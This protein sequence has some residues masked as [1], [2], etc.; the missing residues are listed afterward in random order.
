MTRVGLALPQYRIDVG[1]SADVWD[2]MFGAARAAERNG[3]D[4]V[5]LSDHPFA[6]GPDGT[7]SGALEPVVSAAAL[8]RAIPRIRVGTLVLAGTM[9]APSLLAHS[10][11]G[12]HARLI[13]GLGAGWYEAEHRAFGIALPSYADRVARVEAAID[14]LDALGDA[15][16]EILVGGSGARILDVAARRADAWN[17]AWDLDPAIFHSLTA[18]LDDAIARVGRDP[19]TLRRGVGVTVLVAEDRRGLDRA[20]DRLRARA[21]FLRDLDRRTLAQKIVC[22]S[23]EECAERLAAYDCDEIVAALLLRDDLEMLALFA[24]RVV[25]LLRS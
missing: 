3:L 18:R 5:W 17:V 14:E 7:T 16:P 21:P 25:P 9:R 11:R 20:I 2:A 6:V 23:P 19:A 10:V 8:A 13:A 12:A 15:R 1:E 22:G 4:A 24:E